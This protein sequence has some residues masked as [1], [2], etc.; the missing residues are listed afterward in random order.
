MNKKRIL[1]ALLLS[2]VLAVSLS[3]TACKTPRL[4]PGGVY[5]PTN[6]VGQ[7]IYNDIGLALAD[8]SWKLAYETVLGVME[9][10]RE[11]RQA[12]WD[13]SP[14]IKRSL[15]SIR[16]TVVDIRL[17]WNQARQIYEANPTPAGLTTLQTI[18][19]E[20][21]RLVPVVQA[22]LTPAKAQLGIN[23]NP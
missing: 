8:A 22:Q 12:L 17:R 19:S 10:E 16:P 14:D 5:A 9:F 11:N 21:E 13:I 1:T 23:P 2:S 6:S 20:I 15:D 7:V 18:M 4:E 3:L